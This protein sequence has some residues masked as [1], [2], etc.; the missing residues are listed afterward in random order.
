M[1]EF[2]LF[3]IVLVERSWGIVV[4]ISM[5]SFPATEGDVSTSQLV[6]QEDS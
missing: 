5:R 2:K 3:Y 1:D 4:G 6:M